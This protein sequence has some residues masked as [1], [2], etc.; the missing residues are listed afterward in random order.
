MSMHTVAKTQ[1]RWLVLPSYSHVVYEHDDGHTRTLCGSIIKG[2]KLQVA[3]L[4]SPAV[5]KRCRRCINE[6][7]ERNRKWGGA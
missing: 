5:G 4:R 6:V 2:G 7:R 3:C 1:F